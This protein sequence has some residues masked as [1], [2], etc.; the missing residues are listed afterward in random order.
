MENN[1]LLNKEFVAIGGELY[2]LKLVPFHDWNK[3]EVQELALLLDDDTQ[4]KEALKE[5]QITDS[6][7]QIKKFGICRFGGFDKQGDISD[8]GIEPDFYQCGMRQF[9]PVEGRLC[10][11]VKAPYGTI[12]PAELKVL[13]LI[14]E[15]LPD[16]LIAARLGLTIN[17]VGSHKKSLSKKIGVNSKSGLTRFA[18]EK[19]L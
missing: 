3:A 4:A 5:L 12:T 13:I 1:Y 6:L 16:K 14:A 9:C 7:M 11:A 8:N 10:K 15:D 17:T 19:N 2:K 18:I